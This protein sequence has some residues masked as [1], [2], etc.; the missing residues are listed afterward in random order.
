VKQHF[1]DFDAWLGSNPPRNQLLLAL[2]ALLS[3]E[4]IVRAMADES[5]SSSSSSAETGGNSAT[6]ISPLRR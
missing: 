5:E 6:S 2:A 4:A 1:Q 3:R